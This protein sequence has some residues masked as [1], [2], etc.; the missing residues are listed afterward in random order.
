MFVAWCLLN[1]LAGELHRTTF[2]AGLQKLR[3]RTITPS[4]FLFEYCDEKFTS[5]DL[6]EEGNRFADY[7][8]THET[9]DYIPDYETCFS[10]LPS[11]YHVPDTWTSYDRLAPIIAKRYMKWKNKIDR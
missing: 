2:P 7:Y 6:N 4:Q 3:E 8:F 5:E 1:G 11:T 9:G 10:G